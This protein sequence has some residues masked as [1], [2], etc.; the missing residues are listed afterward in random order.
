MAKL[1]SYVHIL[2][3]LAISLYSDEDVEDSEAIEVVALVLDSNCLK[4][5]ATHSMDF[6]REFIEKHSLWPG[7]VI[8]LILY[9]PEN[10]VSED[11][12]SV[13]IM[14]TGHRIEKLVKGQWNRLSESMGENSTDKG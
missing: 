10:A 5:G 13:E 7:S 2:K 9:G 6:T 4:K 1:K 3:F 11:E 8:K 12:D 14:A